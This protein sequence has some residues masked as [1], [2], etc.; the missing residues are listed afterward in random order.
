MAYL[1]PSGK[2]LEEAINEVVKRIREKLKGMGS[3]ISKTLVS[4]TRN[5]IKE[6]FP[7]SSHYDVE[8]VVEGENNVLSNGAMGESVIGI[9]G[10]SRAWRD[11]T[12]KPVNA[13]MLAI[14]IHREAYGKS[15]T[16]FDN[17]FG[18]RGKRALFKKD[19]GSL[20]AMF[21][22]AESAFQPQDS[23]IAPSDKTYCE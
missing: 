8:K 11:I 6:R 7:G 2:T 21:A 9:P 5:H 15:P 19:G 22:L 3:T 10:F 1:T 23:S 12:I 16:Q 4:T 13:K 18:I 17:L 14:P 20:V